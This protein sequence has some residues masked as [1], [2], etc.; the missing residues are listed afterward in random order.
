M[1]KETF[2]NY[3]NGEFSLTTKDNNLMRFIMDRITMEL[4]QSSTF[5][6][7]NLGSDKKCTN[8]QQ[9]NK[10]T[11]EDVKDILQGKSGKIITNEEFKEKY[12]KKNPDFSVYSTKNSVVDKMKEIYMVL[13]NIY[14]EVLSMPELNEKLGAY[15]YDSKQSM[16]YPIKLLV[17]NNFVKKMKK[18]FYNKNIPAYQWIKR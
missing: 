8:K 5:L 1:N 10:T 16:V 4:R 9:L 13:K 2:F 11:R 12:E 17:E 7:N 15:T 18:E 6:S 3:K 14:P